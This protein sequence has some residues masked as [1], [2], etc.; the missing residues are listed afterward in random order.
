VALTATALPIR[1]ALNTD[2]AN[3]LRVA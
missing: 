1:R 2:P 3:A